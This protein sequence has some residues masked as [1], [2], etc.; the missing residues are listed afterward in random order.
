[1]FSR[2]ETLI[3]DFQRNKHF[4]LNL[5]VT[6]SLSH[7][8]IKLNALFIIHTHVLSF[9]AKILSFQI[10][11]CFEEIHVWISN[12][13]PALG[14]IPLTKATQTKK[15]TAT[16]LGIC[17]FRDLYIIFNDIFNLMYRIEYHKSI[18]PNEIFQAMNT[19]NL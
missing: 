17:F 4:F 9:P 10:D 18:Y 16:F 11:R 13:H 19:I 14:S 12:S 7:K 15:N 6:T 5:D 1:M 3:K 2:G 8:K